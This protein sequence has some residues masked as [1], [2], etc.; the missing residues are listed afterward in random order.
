MRI[1]LS[2]LCLWFTC[3]Q[4]LHSYYLNVAAKFNS[5]SM[6]EGKTGKWSVTGKNRRQIT[7]LDI[8]HM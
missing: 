3:L 8:V 7:Q 5:F 4:A 1:P 6:Y 2:I